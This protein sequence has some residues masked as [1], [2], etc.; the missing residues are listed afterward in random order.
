MENENH[1]A[2]GTRRLAFWRMGLLLLCCVLAMDASAFRKVDAGEIPKLASGEGLLVLSIETSSPISSIRVSKAGGRDS[3][4]NYIPSGRTLQLYTAEEGEYGWKELTLLAGRMG[5]RYK[6]ASD[7]EFKFQVHAGKITYAGELIVRPE[8]LHRVMFHI[9]NRTLPVIDW[10]ETSH[11]A[12]YGAY[13]LQFAGHYPDPFPAFYRAERAT[14][15]EHAGDLNRGRAAPTP[16]ALPLPPRTLWAPSHVQAIALS[17]DGELLA[18]SNWL[19]KGVWSLKLVD[20]KG[21]FEQV[22]I[23]TVFSYDDLSWKDDGTLIASG[24]TPQGASRTM[25]FNVGAVE[26]GKRSVASEQV[27]EQIRIVDLLA[28][29]P[30]TVMY[31]RYDDR[32]KLVVHRLDVS[33]PAAVR[34]MRRHQTRNRLN[35][36]VADDVGWYT[37]GRGEL[38]AVMARRDEEYVLLHGRGDTFTEVLRMGDEDSF[39]PLQLSYDGSEIYG[40]SDEGREQRDLVAFDPATKAVTRTIF[41]KPGVD[42]SSV[43]LG[44]RRTPTA[45]RY[46][47]HGRLATEYFDEQAQA[48]SR[49]LQDAFPGRTVAV[50]DRSADGKQLLLWVEGSDQPAS[51]YHMDMDARRASLISETRPDLADYSFAPAS[52]LSVEGRDGLAIEAFLTLPPGKGKRPLVVMPHGG[53]IG[54]ADRLHFSKEV[55]FI[56]SLGYAVL[57]VNFRGSDGYGR[58]FREAGHGG[59]GTLIE[60]DIDAAIKAAL[61]RYP[62]DESRMCMLGASYGGYSAMVSTIRWPGRF[63]C[64]VSMF[65]VSDRALFF[66]ASDSGRNAKVRTQMERLL[67]N[68]NTEMEAMKSNS[69]LY[70][71]RDLKVPVLLLHGREDFRVD[72]EHTRRLVRMLN[73]AERPPVVMAFIGEAHG[74]DRISNIDTAWTGIAGFLGRHLGGVKAAAEVTPA[75]VP[76][77]PAG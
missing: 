38:R 22:L 27:P 45:V 12:L 17:P 63:R 18:E 1:T 35:T 40:L 42:I 41:S 44:K 67:G 15:P 64:A 25:V 77:S 68:P 21:A 4:L 60:D 3:L 32:G 50:L 10:L 73:L 59:Y 9:S 26:N 46:Y 65:G 57:Q 19:R 43:V 23:T 29:E 47:E 5:A 54:V 52:V 6:L 20:L 7:P 75:E 8:S 48:V 14:L 13:Q 53:P 30:G 61:A 33:S 55:Q 71:Y 70:R 74:L 69:P 37:D 2:G 39:Q 31:Q 66:T 36:A 76:P 11:P 34:E 28:N 72:F 16:A 51:V 62:L 49:Q 24:T 58:A 56:A